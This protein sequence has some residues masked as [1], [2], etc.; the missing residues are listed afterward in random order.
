[1]SNFHYTA[2]TSSIHVHE[3]RWLRCRVR[4]EDGEYVDAEMDLNCCIGND[5]GHFQWGGESKNS[6]TLLCT[7]V[8][9]Q[10]RP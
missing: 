7:R 1:M 5:N 10:T 6:P 8:S 3:G 2:E 9:D 4:R